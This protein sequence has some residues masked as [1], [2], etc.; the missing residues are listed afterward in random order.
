[1][2]ECSFNAVDTPALLLDLSALER[3]IARMAEFFACRPSALRPHSK[4]HKCSHIAQMQV[5]AGA[6]GITCAKV[7]EAEAMADGGIG[8]VLI[9]NEIVTP[10][11]IARLMALC[12]RTRVT[13]AV[14][15]QENV[16]NLSLAAAAAG[17][18]LGVLVEV[19][20]GM[21]RCGVEPGVAAVNLARQVA[22]QPG[23]RFRGVMGYEGHAVMLPSAEQ[24]KAA[25]VKAMG[26][27]AK[28]AEGIRAAGLPVDVVSVG[29]TGTYEFSGDY[30]SV[31]EVQA[32]SYATMDA[33]YASVGVGFEQ[34]IAVLCTVISRPR[35]DLLVV[36]AGVK[37]ISS[38][39]GMPLVA[40]VP[41]AVVAKL[42]EEHGL[43]TLAHPEDVRLAPGDTVQL[44]PSHGCTT[45]NLH[46]RYCVHQG[47]QLQG[48]WPI[49]A[50]GKFA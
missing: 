21:N 32:G 45:I 47:G 42:S 13:V 25:A 1:M 5:A 17:V 11:K 19:N 37:A 46:D 31:T 6:V 10:I 16:R 29:G 33:R 4:T 44:I 30:P 41:G 20:V 14:D 18:E 40:E 38:D 22:G 27:L 43:I 9:A 28:S 24:R 35:R 34:A 50:R 15:S 12:R 26:L 8:D 23:L 7:G 3:N 2:A 48:F 36:D 39:F 49:E